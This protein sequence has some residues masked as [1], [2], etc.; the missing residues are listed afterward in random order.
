MLVTP[1][2]H[3]CASLRTVSGSGWPL[4][5]LAKI[6]SKT[7]PGGEILAKSV[8]DDRSF[9]SSGE[10]KIRDSSWLPSGLPRLD[11]PSQPWLLYGPAGLGNF[12]P[13]EIACRGPHPAVLPGRRR[14]I[15]RRRKKAWY[16]VDG[17]LL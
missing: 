13:R 6:C 9:M 1:R 12:K 17:G 16:P 2:H 11:A 5:N 7:K 15:L 3:G 4:K 14:A 10:P 8:A